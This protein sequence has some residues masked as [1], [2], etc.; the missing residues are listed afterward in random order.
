MS[1]RVNRNKGW[2]TFS[3]WIFY[4]D[5]KKNKWYSKWLMLRYL[6]FAQRKI[7]LKLSK[8]K[9]NQNQK[10]PINGQ[11]IIVAGNLSLSWTHKYYI[12]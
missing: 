4:A 2:N 12:H 10:C 1:T 5:I 7:Q 3:T 11:S 6:C 8:Y 9:N